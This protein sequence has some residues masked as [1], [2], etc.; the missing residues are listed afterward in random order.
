MTFGF[1]N[2][3][4]LLGLAGLAIPIIVH[5]LHRRRFDVVDWGAMQFL[6]I[7]ET[8]RRRLLLEEIILMA[9]RMSLIAILVLGLAAPFVVSSLLAKVMHDRPSRDVVL[10]IDG[11]ASMAYERQGKTA[12]ESAKAWAHS[13]L[14]ELSSNDSV[15]LLLA[16][17]QVVPLAGE[18][19]HD[20]ASL[21]EKIDQLSTPSGSADLPE[22]IR[23]GLRILNERSKSPERDIIVLSDGQKYG[24]ADDGALFHWKLL[25]G[26]FEHGSAVRPRL[27]VVNLDADR[28]ANPANWTLTPIRTPRPVAHVHEDITF[29][30]D[31]V[32]SGQ[33]A[34]VPPYKIHLEVDGKE[35]S[36]RIGVPAK[37][38]LTQGQAPLTFHHRFET[39]GSHVLSVVVEPDPPP[40]KRPPGYQRRDELAVD[41]R[42]DYALE[43]LPPLLVLTVDGEKDGPGGSKRKGIT[44]L[45]DALSPAIDPTPEVRV[46]V[47]PVGELDAEALGHNLPAGDSR[48]PRVLILADVPR[49]SEAQQKAVQEYL[50]SGGG[51]FVTLGSQVDERF[52]NESANWLPAQLEQITTAEKGRPARPLEGGLFHP[53]LDRFR[54]DPSSWGRLEFQRWWKLRPAT[55][56]TVVARLTNDNPLLVEQTSAAGRVL[57]CTVPLNPSWE[58]NIFGLPEFPVL[59]HEIVNYLAGVRGGEFGVRSA[60]YNL[61]PGQPLRFRLEGESWN[62]LTLQR[63]DEGPLPLVIDGETHQTNAPR[64]GVHPAQLLQTPPTTAVSYSGTDSVGVYRLRTEEKKTYYYTGQADV[65][66]SNLSPCTN[67]DWTKI[68]DLIPMTYLTD[69]D[70]HNSP[71]A[72]ELHTEELWWWLMLGVIG[73]LCAELWMTRRIVRGR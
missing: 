1:L 59:A 18:L 42:R 17:K 61:R 73:L 9:L 46:Q 40:E 48:K 49:L 53:I 13:L 30:T 27:W 56:A 2:L 29:R 67:E 28:A 65:E 12:F 72:S 34:Y 66:E 41:N 31:L 8:T 23:E 39:P 50:D 5:L 44:F 11:S 3:I 15:A 10:I 43:V 45:R 32:L 20:R 6:Q 52:Y 25:A 57:L 21:R 70:A 24:W 51:L 16:R 47:V 38:S 26:L 7:S 19:T 4:M 37:S 54:S 71:L 63:P 33:T 69:H 62:A 58:T 35:I 68:R 64:S 36:D 14:Q 60:N 22:A 55:T